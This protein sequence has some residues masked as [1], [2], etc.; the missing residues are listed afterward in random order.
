MYQLTFMGGQALGS[1]VWGLVAG[2]TTLVISL[3][4]SAGLLGVCALS[5]VWWPLHAKTGNI[6][7]SLSTHWPEPTLEFEPEPLDGPVLVMTEYRVDAVDEAEFFAAMSVLGRSRQRTGAARWRLYRSIE[8]EWVF[9][10]TFIVRSWGEHLHQ[11]H[12]RQTAQD[13]L[14]EQGVARFVDG[15]SHHLV[16]VRTTR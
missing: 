1:L 16:A 7:L 9:A 14:I 11:H 12:T 8:R 10:E 6:N 4:V 13:L 5:L 2:A 3:L 15:V